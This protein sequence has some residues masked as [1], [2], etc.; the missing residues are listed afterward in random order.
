M[1]KPFSRTSA[2]GVR[3]IPITAEMVCAIAEPEVA[4]TFVSPDDLAIRCEVHVFQV[5]EVD[6]R[7]DPGSSACANL[8]VDDDSRPFAR[9]GMVKRVLLGAGWKRCGKP[10]PGSDTAASSAQPESGR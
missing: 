8:Y 9:F 4:E 2:D 1:K 3:I 6:W 7:Q 5:G 10:L